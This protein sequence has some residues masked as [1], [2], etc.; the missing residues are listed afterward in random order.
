MERTLDA[1]LENAYNVDRMLLLDRNRLA[2]VEGSPYR[3]VRLY[4]AIRPTYD[5]NLF[6]AGSYLNF[7][8]GMMRDMYRAGL[9]AASDWLAQGPPVD[10]LEGRT[11]PDRRSA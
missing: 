9:R 10:R 7:Q 1:F 4:D 6:S 11:T 3:E 2:H 5:R 8:R